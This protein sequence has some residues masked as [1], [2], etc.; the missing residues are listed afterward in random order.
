MSQRK[1]AWSQKSVTSFRSGW[2]SLRTTSI[3]GDVPFPIRVEAP[4]YAY[5]VTA[6]A[7]DGC[8]LF[9]DDEDRQGFLVLLARELRRSSWTCF[10]YSLMGT[11]YHLLIRLEKCTLSSGFQ[12]LNSA[13]ARSFNSKYGRRGALWQRRFHDVLVESDNHLLELNRYIAWN[14]PRVNLATRP[15]EYPWC[16]YGAAIG[17]VPPDPL[18]DEGEL[19]ALFGTSTALARRR[20]REFVEERDPRKRRLRDRSEKSQS[21]R[22]R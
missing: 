9:R 20:L 6:N 16:S 17:V 5:H 14:A 19:L 2:R 18:I 1:A 11:H 7:I 10:A 21:R 3:V 22:G 13:Y 12:H 15:E 4:G 8:R